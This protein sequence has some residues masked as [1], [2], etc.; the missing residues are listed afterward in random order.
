MSAPIPLRQDFEA[1]QLRGFINLKT[2]KALSITVPPTMLGL[3][4]EVI[5]RGADRI[6]TGMTKVLY[7]EHNV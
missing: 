5:E 3:A 1:S 7:V 4:D 6:G 2:A